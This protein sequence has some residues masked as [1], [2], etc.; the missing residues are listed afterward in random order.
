MEAASSSKM[1]ST[2]SAGSTRSSILSGHE[3]DS[4]FFDEALQRRH[5]RGAL[6]DDGLE[7]AVL[8]LLVGDARIHVEREP[9]EQRLDSLFAVDLG[10]CLQRFPAIGSHPALV[11]SLDGQLL[12]RRLSVLFAEEVEQSHEIGDGLPE[13]PAG[14]NAFAEAD[15]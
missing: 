13:P 10:Q 4:D 2:S 7:D 12:H 6:G 15:P 5:R 11:S 3:S 8:L 9:M 1:A 14:R